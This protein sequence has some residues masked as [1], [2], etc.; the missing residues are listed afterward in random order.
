MAKRCDAKWTFDNTAHMKASSKILGF[1]PGLEPGTT[2]L[3]LRKRRS[4][5]VGTKGCFYAC[6]EMGVAYPKT[7]WSIGIRR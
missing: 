6:L 1:G 5:T 4:T 2:T 3:A 7:G